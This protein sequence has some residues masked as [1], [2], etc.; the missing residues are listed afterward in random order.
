MTLMKPKPFRHN[1]W[2]KSYKVCP[3]CGK[4]FYILDPR[5]NKIFCDSCKRDK[6]KDLDHKQYL[7]KLK[8]EQELQ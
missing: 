1:Q 5:G 8:W 4:P 6:T 2:S 7:N 3:R